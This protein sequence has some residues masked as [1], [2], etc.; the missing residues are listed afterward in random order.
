MKTAVL[1]SG[2]MDSLALAWWKR[3]DILIN[4]D[5]GQLPASAE[6]SAAKA[7][8]ARLGVPL[9][10]VRVDCSAVGSGDM[11]GTTPDK[12]APD[13]DWWPFR[14]QLLVTLAGAKAIS[15]GVTHLWLGT[16]RSDGTHQDGTTAF[17]DAI[18]RLTQMQEGGLVIEAPAIS[19]STVGLI[20][21]AQ[22]P[23]NLLA[24]AHSC[25][26]AN[27]PCGECRGCNKYFY[28]LDELNNALGTSE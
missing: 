21:M 6:R 1:L 14:N 10:E 4:I 12:L 28:V 15:L 27:I 18:S 26:V 7:I 25:H 19:F 22:V 13:S 11:A 2:G 20:R 24:W 8:S 16:V 5:Y 3:P 17:I 23:R 9:H